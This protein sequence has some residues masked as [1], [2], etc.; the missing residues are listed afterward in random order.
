MP[1]VANRDP[2]CYRKTQAK[3]VYFASGRVCAIKP[4][5]DVRQVGFSNADPI[6]LDCYGGIERRGAETHSNY[7]RLIRILNSIVKDGPR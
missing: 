6:I 7:S 4:L 5:K 3:S 2:F 1:S